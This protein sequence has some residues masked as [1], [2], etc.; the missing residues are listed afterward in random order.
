MNTGSSRAVSARVNTTV[1]A[2]AS[3]LRSYSRR[4]KLEIGKDVG[5]RLGAGVHHRALFGVAHGLGIT[6]QRTRLVFGLPR[7]PRLAPLGQFLVRELDRKRAVDR[8]HH[9]DVAILQQADRAAHGSL[10]TDMPD[11]EAARA[12]GE[13][14][15]GDERHVV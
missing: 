9:D 11:A 10:G 7:L 5:F 3:V 14:A 6:P 13:A 12:A 15:V 8:V 4:S 2:V 1:A